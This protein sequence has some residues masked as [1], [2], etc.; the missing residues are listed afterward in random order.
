MTLLHSTHSFRN[1]SP[2]ADVRDIG[3]STLQLLGGS[4]ITQHDS[5]QLGV[6]E[7]VLRLDISVADLEVVN[8]GQRT[9]HLVGVDLGQHVRELVPDLV[10]V[11]QDFV[12]RVWNVVHYQVQVNVRFFFLAL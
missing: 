9:Q 10:V 5:V 1:D 12:Q 3:L 11:P 8:V 6:N 4:E 7:N 2:R